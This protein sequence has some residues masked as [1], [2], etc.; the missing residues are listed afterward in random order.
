M[1]FVFLMFQDAPVP[2]MSLCDLCLSRV[3]WSLEQL[4]DSRAD[5]SLRLRRAPS[6]PTETAD[7][8]LHK[9]TVE[10]RPR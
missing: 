5:G 1:S 8:L 4:C 6:L 9:M 2:V 7:Q 3:C 10:G